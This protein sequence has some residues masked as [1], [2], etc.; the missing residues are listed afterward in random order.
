[1]AEVYF[2]K[3]IEKIMDEVDI[4]KLGKN[5][6]IK[7]HFGERGCVT[8][9]NPEI[10]KKVYDKV[11]ASGRKATLVECNVLYKGSRTTS[12]EHLKVAREHGFD[13]A[14]ID[15]LDGEFGREYIEVAIENGKIESVKIGKGIKKYDSMIVISHFKG[16]SDAGYGG[17]FKNVG[18]GLGS[19]AG[20]LQMH[21]HTKPF[22]RS[23]N[24]IVCNNCIDHCDYDAISLVDG[25]AFI[26]DEKCVGCSMCIAVCPSRAVSVP[27][28][29]ST[30]EEVQRKIVDYTEGVMKL[31]PNTFF[32]NILE[33]ITKECD[34]VS[35]VQ[36]PMMKDVGILYS[37]DIVAIDKASLNLADKYSN[38]E[39]DK[40]NDV[41][42]NV[43]VDYAF[44]KG[45]GEKD[46]KLIDLDK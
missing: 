2:S 28:G 19:R 31:I 42:K 18:M 29:G 12:T 37:K 25:K 3:D 1:M 7:I 44:S 24:C 16:H 36:E 39:F 30:H 13:F 43:Q 32:I 8:Y 17:A 26:D 6:A 14:P 35:I 33:N 11:V 10:V 22:V 41:D 4:S 34:C 46:Y 23:K 9:L 21:S 15:I 45:L 38:G 5:I 20:K 27:W 40:I